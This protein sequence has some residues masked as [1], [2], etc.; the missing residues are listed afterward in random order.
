LKKEEIYHLETYCCHLAENRRAHHGA[1]VPP[2]FQ[3]SLFTFKDWEHAD[4]AFED[5]TENLIYSRGNNPTVNITEKKLAKLAGAERALLFGSGMAAVSAA[6]LHCVSANDHIIA[7]QNVYGP[8]NGFISNYLKD[9]FNISVSFVK[10]DHLDQFKSELQPNTKL[11]YLESPSSGVFG[12]Q[13]ISEI[14]HWAKQ[15][16]IKTIIDNSW[17]SPYFQKPISLGIDIEVHS[18][19]KYLG[20]HSDIVA[21]VIMSTHEIIKEIFIN[22]YELFGARISPLEAWLLNRSIRTLSMRMKQHQESALHIARYLENHEKIEAVYF[23]G[24]ESHPQYALAQKL[25]SGYSGLMG[26]RLKTNNLDNI[27]AFFNALKLFQIGVS[28]G[29][30]ESLI[31]ALAISYMKELKP[32]QFAQLGISLGDMRISVGLEH[33]EDLIFDLEQA[34][35][36]I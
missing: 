34:L 21:G 12:L 27:K 14:C 5:R 23:P 20:G 29:G 3:N 17:A 4:A 33:Y 35:S 8:T 11:I 18:C 2:I 10:G 30:H 1:V 36:L 6:I 32:E 9:K 24:L 31:Y 15:N 28:W 25:M 13:D 22:E 16:R 7:I 26:F 19:T